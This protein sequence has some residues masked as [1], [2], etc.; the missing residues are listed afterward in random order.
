MTKIVILS[1]NYAG[2]VQCAE[3]GFSAYIEH[4]DAKLIY[5][6]GQS[7]D[8]VLKNA[9]ELNIDLSS[10]EHIVLSHGH[11]DHT[12][13]LSK[14]MNKA[15]RAQVWCHSEMLNDKFTVGTAGNL[16][17]AG[18]NSVSTVPTEKFKTFDSNFCIADGIW[19]IT[20]IPMSHADEDIPKK[21]VLTAHDASIKQD[22]FADECVLAIDTDE[23]AVVLVGCAHRGVMNTLDYVSS[24]LK[25]KIRGVIGGIHLFEATDARVD[26]TVR[27]FQERNIQLIGLSHCTG[28]S[29]LFK[30]KQKLGD[31]V[32]PAVGGTIFNL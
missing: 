32:I 4:R 29:A 30:M 14:L 17:A 31:K 3:W 25:K 24:S 10:A 20:N 12:G 23:G 6:T 21:F 9:I 16:K 26:E 1:D 19:I 7:G 15:S 13:G 11:Y 2:K 28:L 18:L 5:D 27:Y 8:V 22:T